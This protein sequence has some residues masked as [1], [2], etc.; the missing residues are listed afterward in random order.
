M[1]K[2]IISLLVSVAV[3]VGVLCIAI[4][5]VATETN[6]FILKAQDTAAPG[7]TVTYTLYLK[8][9]RDI[10]AFGLNIELPDGFT[11][12]E[13]SLNTGNL[14]STL[15]LVVPSEMIALSA[16]EQANESPLLSWYSPEGEE[17]TSRD[18]VLLATF[19]CTVPS[20]AEVGS[21]YTISLENALE[22]A[23]LESAYEE[24]KDIALTPHTLTVEAA[25]SYL[26]GDVNLDGEI[27]ALDLTALARHVA[28]IEFITDSVALVNA[29]T[30][31]DNT[32]SAEDLTLLAR[33]VAK[34]IDSFN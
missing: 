9:S 27:T 22:A 21:A 26:I 32:V 12:V 20:D 8:N 2:R 29:D 4:P 17:L 1:K 6:Q 25:I 15:D 13:K 5:M 31:F 14:F 34:I 30:N 23:G 7:E 28:K 11:L 16:D 33:Y 3:I 19:E 18:E 10:T 24:I